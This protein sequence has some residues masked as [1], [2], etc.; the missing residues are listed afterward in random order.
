[1]AIN[2]K[3]TQSVMRVVES[4]GTRENNCKNNYV[5]LYQKCPWPDQFLLFS[6]H[7]RYVHAVTEVITMI[8]VPQLAACIALWKWEKEINPQISLQTGR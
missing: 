8:S 2:T 3:Y 5:A 1:M 7:C 6:K 4:S